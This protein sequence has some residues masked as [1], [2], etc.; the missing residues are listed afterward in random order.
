MKHILILLI[1]FTLGFASL[2][3]INSFEADFTQSVTDENNKVLSYSGLIMAAKP[4]NVMWDYEKPI[5]KNVYI[6]TESVTIVEPEIEQVIV[7]EIESNFNFFNMIKN[8]KKVKENTFVATYKESI[9]TITTKNSFIKSI[10]YTDEF[11]NRVVIT[12]DNQKQNESI[13]SNVFVPKI[14]T[15]FDIIRD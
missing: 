3:E 15:D 12:F 9:F 8:A 2:D 7:K 11:E 10:S 6:N 1:S 13:N 5:K 14:P 4:Q